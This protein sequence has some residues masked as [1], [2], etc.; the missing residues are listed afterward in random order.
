MVTLPL[1]FDTRESI[2]LL[3]AITDR[4]ALYGEINGIL[5]I[6]VIIVV[7]VVAIGFNR[8]FLV[9]GIQDQKGSYCQ[10]CETTKH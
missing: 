8:R 2:F 7:V 3:G 6:I 4:Y 10:C 5:S 1:D 9:A